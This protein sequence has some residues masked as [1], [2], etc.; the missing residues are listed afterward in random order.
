MKSAKGVSLAK[1]KALWH[2]YNEAIFEGRLRV[3]VLRITRSIHYYG[4]CCIVLTNTEPKVAIYISG[5]FARDNP[6]SIDDTLVHEMVHQWQFEQ[7]LRFDDNHDETFMQ[8]LPV[9]KEKT[10][11]VL[12]ES[13]NE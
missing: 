1:V 8:W 13:W 11:L 7:G 3:P 4:R 9:I 6:T 10:G 5:V 2:K 12:Q